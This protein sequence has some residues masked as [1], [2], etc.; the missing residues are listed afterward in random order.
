MTGKLI[1][2]G[3]RWGKKKTHTTVL[4]E[5][6][7]QGPRP[8]TTVLR[9]SHQKKMKPETSRVLRLHRLCILNLRDTTEPNGHVC[10]GGRGSSWRY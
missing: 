9:I 4:I 5:A 2:L 7:L 8:N 6:R 1:N 10:T 3:E